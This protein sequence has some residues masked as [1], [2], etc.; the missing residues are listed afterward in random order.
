[1]NKACL[2]LLS[3]FAMNLNILQGQP[4]QPTWESLDQRPVA[5]WF[6]DAKLGIFIHW[7]P[8]S[9]PAWSPR[10]T[11]SE[12]YQYWLQT[13][14]LF[15]NGDFEG[16]EVYDF[17]VATYGE[18][19][20]YFQFGEQFTAELYDP[21]HWAEVFQRAGAKYV[22][23]TSK[24]HDGF[25]LWPNPQANDRG[26]AWNAM[27]VGAKRDLL[28]D[29]TDAVKEQGL[30]MGYYYSLYE[31]FHPWWMDESQ[32]ERFVEEHFHPQFKDLV[33]KYQPDIMWGD[34]E[35][36]MEAEAWKTP[37]L[38]AWL[39][40]ESSVKDKVVVNDRW[41]KGVRHKHGGYYTTEYESGLEEA[42]PWEECRGM[43]FSFGYNRAETARDYNTPQ[44][45]VLML[46]DV[47]SR[48]GNLLL[49]IGPSGDGRIP[50]IMEDRLL[51]MGAWLDLYG[52]AIYGTRPWKNPVQWTAGSKDFE[53]LFE[54][55]RYLSGEYILK[56]TVEPVEG[57]ARKE[58]FFTRKGDHLYAIAPL[59]PGDELTLEGIRAEDGAEVH[60]LAT[61][62]RLS[63][64]QDGDNLVIR[65]PA[66]DPV[67]VS[68]PATYAYV[69]RVKGI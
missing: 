50:A 29:L 60:F 45:L 54:G 21:A 59:W 24:H 46:V 39:F 15:G 12:W 26:F 14:Q 57:Y 51:D 23:L 25:T 33:E 40:N 32:R 9:V 41:G 43:G 4:Y 44:T 11:Y 18:E 63:W 1:M 6:E 7:G 17:H 35:W 19:T 36:E 47:V 53:K 67:K 65:M 30:K 37:E 58:V 34:G 10:G 52:E 5:P 49:D 28:G 61:G 20:D 68:G 55:Q 27:E 16:P 42:H 56:Q 66:F 69:F 2:F 64:K 22:V 8:Y 38:L 13:R 3:M 48:G 62:E 31:W